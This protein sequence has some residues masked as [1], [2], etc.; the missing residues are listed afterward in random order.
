MQRLIC[1]AAVA[2]ALAALPACSSGTLFNATPVPL[3]FSIS[4]AAPQVGKTSQLKGVAQMSD[5]SAKDVTADTT[6]W[7][8]SDTAVATVSSTGLVTGVASGSFTVTAT[9]QGFTAVTPTLTVP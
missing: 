1:S 7:T 8:S 4:G 2:L 9:Y 3:A 6:G 5:G